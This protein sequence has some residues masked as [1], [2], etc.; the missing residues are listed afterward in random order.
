MKADYEAM[1]KS[2]YIVDVYT[3]DE[4]DSKPVKSKKLKKQKNIISNSS[5]SDFTISWKNQP[6]SVGFSNKGNTCFLNASLQVLL[7]LPHWQQW[8]DKEIKKNHLCHNDQK[9]K[10]KTSSKCLYCLTCKQVKAIKNK[11]GKGSLEPLM[12]NKNVLEYNFPH[13][14]FGEQGDA[15]DFFGG[16]LQKL[17]QI[18]NRDNLVHKINDAYGVNERRNVLCEH[19]HSWSEE[20]R[21]NLLL[22]A[23]VNGMLDLDACLDMHFKQESVTQEC[24]T[25]GKKSRRA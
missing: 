9:W 4:L 20:D 6:K 10:G 17:R 24:R 21:G 12:S 11:K 3:D 16:F 13:L 14:K 22:H 2:I 25:C 15:A 7:A 5:I 1:Q 8:C 18:D 23:P 19:N